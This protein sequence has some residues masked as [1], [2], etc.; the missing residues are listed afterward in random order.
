MVA[1][2]STGYGYGLSNMNSG[3]MEYLIARCFFALSILTGSV[4]LVWGQ[5][6]DPVIDT[7]TN[8]QVHKE[9]MPQSLCI[10]DSG[11]VHLVWKQQRTGGWRIFYRTNS[12]A[13]NWGAIQEVIDS[14]Q[15]S[16]DPALAWW[17]LTQ[18]PFIVYEQDSEI[19]SAF[20]SGSTWQA[21]PITQNMQLDRSPTIAIDS[22]W[23]LPHVAWITD[24][25]STGQYKIAYAMAYLV[26]PYI[27]WDI[28]TLT[29]SDL[30][31]YG[32]GAAP[33]ITVSHQEIAH[34]FYRG[35][36]YGD[37]HVHH[38]WNDAP[39]SAN[40]S[41]EIIYSGNANDFSAA[42]AFDADSGLHLAVSGNDGWGF[43]G[44]VFYFFKPAGQPWQQYE[45]A[46][47]SASAMQPSISIDGNNEPHIVWMETSGNIYTGHV[48]Y[49]SRDSAGSWHV[50]QVIGNDHFIPSFQIDHEG[51]GH[52][53]CHTGG[54]TGLYDIYHILSSGVLTGLSEYDNSV[55]CKG[56]SLNSFPN[57]AYGH[58]KITYAHEIPIHITLKVYNGIGEEVTTLVDEVS[59]AGVHEKSWY[60]EDMSAGVYFF[61]IKAGDME[62]GVKCVLY[63]R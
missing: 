1:I 15:A 47:L 49:S 12:P 58:T 3:K 48:F 26:G 10:D 33:F 4:S 30:G 63:N 16:F 13:G 23:L 17:S 59:V 2:F 22:L 53:A 37:Y 50:T 31:P 11:Y 40:W 27:H 18:M 9:T 8:T 24:D 61:H 42:A 60:A 36:D 41:Y 62:E 46:S 38:A 32:T 29:G 28:Q 45:L 39:G 6:T 25:S 57:P 52:I 35:G 7:I 20:L 44:R 54:N 56:L 21:E 51:Y 5:W 19:Y 43:P 34:I 14:S 55:G